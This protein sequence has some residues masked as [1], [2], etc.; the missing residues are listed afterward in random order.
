MYLIYVTIIFNVVDTN[1]ANYIPYADDTAL[2]VSV[3]FINELF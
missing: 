3:N 2:A 1:I